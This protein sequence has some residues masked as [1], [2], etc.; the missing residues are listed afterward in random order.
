MRLSLVSL[1]R[2][3]YSGQAWFLSGLAFVHTL[4]RSLTCRVG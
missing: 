4:L 2:T 3:D 1:P